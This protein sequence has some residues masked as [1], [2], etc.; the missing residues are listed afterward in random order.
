MSF[1]DG[2]VPEL[3]LLQRSFYIYSPFS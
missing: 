2:L 3:P 1:F